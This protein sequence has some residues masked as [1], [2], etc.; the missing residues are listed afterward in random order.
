[1]DR[2]ALL[3]PT[4]VL[5]LA[6]SIALPAFAP[7]D[8][9]AATLQVTTC[10]D[11][12]PGSLRAVAAIAASGDTI[13]LRRL[14]CTP[15]NVTSGE[16]VL[17]QA[18]LRILG[19]SRTAHTLRADGDNRVLLHA[20]TG[21]LTLQNLS[22]SYGGVTGVGASGGC[23]LSAGNVAL[24][25]ARV[26]HCHAT[27]TTR[28]EG[29]VGGGGVMAAGDV[30]L[31]DASAFRNTAGSG[32]GGGVFAG[33]KARLQ[34]SQVY[35][36]SADVAGGGIEAH[37][38]LSLTYS[39]LLRN[40]TNGSGGGARA[41]GELALNKST[42]AE[43]TAWRG[44]ALYMGGAGPHV[45]TDSTVSGNV[46][47]GD[48][49]GVAIEGSGWTQ[50]F[51]STFANN[52]ESSLGCWGALNG[53]RLWLSSV[54][55]DFNV[56]GAGEYDIGEPLNEQPGEIMGSNNMVFASK[57][58]LPPDTF[59]ANVRLGPLADNGGPVRTHMPGPTS[60]ALN[61]GANLLNRAYDQRGAGFPRVKGSAPDIGAVEF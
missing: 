22:V 17:P 59:W 1:M 24:R 11:S 31:V 19:A 5:L 12:G 14:A 6:A 16:V 37:G 51:N 46:A 61:R 8:V 48:A 10:A 38:G 13:D 27:S 57:V 4:P 55:F 25:G 43:N 18:T 3:A 26:H 58:A 45:I 29:P 40:R 56:C 9:Q 28:I 47:D 50:V 7:S 23:V 34:Y 52:S 30:L 32:A 41:S 15:I 53:Q 44:G 35:D 20:G 36:N 54:L 60:P 42:L 2:T 33:G 39:M 21:T 49:S